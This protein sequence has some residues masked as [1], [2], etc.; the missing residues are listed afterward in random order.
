LFLNSASKCLLIS[1]ATLLA[2][3][4]SAKLKNEISQNGS[5]NLHYNSYMPNV[6]I[7]IRISLRVDVVK[8]YTSEIFIASVSTEFIADSFGFIFSCI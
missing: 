3:I 4:R 7:D 5:G 2:G 8:K 6:H 1:S